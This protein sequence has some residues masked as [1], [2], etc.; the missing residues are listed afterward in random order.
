MSAQRRRDPRLPGWSIFE[1]VETVVGGVT[2]RSIP[3]LSDVDRVIIEANDRELRS[4]RKLWGRDRDWWLLPADDALRAG[5]YEEC[6]RIMRGWCH[7]SS[8]LTQYDNREPDW[9]G[10]WML[11]RAY[12]GLGD[13]AREEATIRSWLT[14]WPPDRQTTNKNRDKAV[15]RLRT[16]QG[17]CGRTYRRPLDP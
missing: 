6:V 5:E 7:T 16:V 14:H 8:R 11:A 12:R 3:R 1:D 4:R 2:V 9:H 13:S 15:K 10:Y 17:R